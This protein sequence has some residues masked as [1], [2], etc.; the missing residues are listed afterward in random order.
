[1]L[2]IAQ[3]ITLLKGSISSSLPR[4]NLGGRVLG[5]QPPKTFEL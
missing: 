5:L 4:V 1:M 2:S 3:Q